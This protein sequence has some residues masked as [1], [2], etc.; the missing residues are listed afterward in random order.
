[1]KLNTI[2]AST[3]AWMGLSL[4]SFAADPVDFKKQIKPLL[5]QS[6]LKCH[7]GEKPKGG[8]RLDTRASAIKGGDA[9]TSLAPG[10]PLESPLYATTILAADHDDVMPPQPKERKLTK[11]ETDL[12]KG[13]IEQGATWPDDVVLSAVKRVDFVKDIQPILEM[14]CVTCHKEANKKGGFRVDSKELA[15]QGGDGGKGIVPRQPDASHVYTST[16][17]STNDDKL[18]PPLGK[19]GPLKKDETD[20]LRHWIEQGADWPD[21]LMLVQKAREESGKK[22]EAN[23]GELA[24]VANIHRQLL[25]KLDVQSEAGMKPYTNTISGTQ[26]TFTMVPLKAGDFM[27]GSLASETGGQPDERPPHKVKI[28]PF[29]MGAYEVTWSEYELF[30][31]QDEERKFQKEIPTDPYVDK[32]SDAVARPTKPYV[33]MIARL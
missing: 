31:Y 25:A 28:E 9:G 15:F 26:V 20:L 23:A 2:V 17:V 10:K 14:N 21:G 16:I 4:F 33:E 27:M 3:L 6:C 7:G 1:M 18:M 12:L 24:V 29:W 11:A 30:M 19:G 8:L 5:E 13:W 32:I 22:E